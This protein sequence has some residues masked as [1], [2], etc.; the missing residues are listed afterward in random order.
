MGTSY[1]FWS[2]TAP[3]RATT[4]AGASPSY[5][6]Q[7]LAGSGLGGLVVGLAMARSETPFGHSLGQA[8]NVQA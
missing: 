2:S 5:P 7:K 6:P 4:Q 8:K 1:P 3:V